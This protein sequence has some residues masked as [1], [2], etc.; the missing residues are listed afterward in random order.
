LFHFDQGSEWLLCWSTWYLLQHVVISIE[1]FLFTENS[2]ILKFQLWKPNAVNTCVKRSSQCSFKS[3]DVKSFERLEAFN[4]L[5]VNLK[6]WRHWMLICK[7]WLIDLLSRCTSSMVNFIII[8]WTNF[9]AVD[10]LSSN[11]CMT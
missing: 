8:L 5:Q 3:K 11:S 1:T 9:V 10:L 2:N 4:K 6:D 7:T